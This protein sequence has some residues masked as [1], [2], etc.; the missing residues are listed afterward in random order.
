L[1]YEPRA[2]AQIGAQLKAFDFRKVIDNTVVDRLV[3]QGF[4]KLFGA[5]IKVEEDKKARLASVIPTSAIAAEG[6]P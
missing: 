4:E 3:K 5:G 2:D 1:F 6:I